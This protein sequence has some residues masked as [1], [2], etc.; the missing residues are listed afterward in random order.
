MG[1]E[2]KS[3]QPVKDRE[4]RR[5]SKSEGKKEAT[6]DQQAPDFKLQALDPRETSSGVTRPCKEFGDYLSSSRGPGT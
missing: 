2:R 5:Q 6:P 1:P 4:Y 3:T